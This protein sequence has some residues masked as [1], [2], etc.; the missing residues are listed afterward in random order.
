MTLSQNKT[1]IN[2]IQWLQVL[3][4]I[5]TTSTAYQLL[6]SSA[7]RYKHMTSNMSLLGLM[8]TSTAYQLLV[9]SAVRYTH[10]L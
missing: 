8:Y 9:S 3:L 5:F 2:K 7:V 6:V 1:H 4:I 10:D